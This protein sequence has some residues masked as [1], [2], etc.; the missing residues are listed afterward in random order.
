MCYFNYV[1]AQCVFTKSSQLHLSA[2]LA[3]QHMFNS[4]SRQ[5]YKM[6][7]IGRLVLSIGYVTKFYAWRYKAAVCA[8]QTSMH[9]G[10]HI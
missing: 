3:T 7:K 8:Y 2:L 6:S 4:K 9:D 1:T 10:V 5:R